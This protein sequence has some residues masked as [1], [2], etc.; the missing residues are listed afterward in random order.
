LHANLAYFSTLYATILAN[1]QADAGGR[2][3]FLADY[4]KMIAAE[5]AAAD[6]KLTALSR[7]RS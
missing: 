1:R 2:A 7:G 6:A 4:Q 3:T 5:K